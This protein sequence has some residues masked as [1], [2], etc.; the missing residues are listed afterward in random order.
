MELTAY[1]EEQI[2]RARASP[3]GYHEFLRYRSMNAGVYVLPAGGEDRQTPHDEDELY[4]VVR[5]R[6]RF[7]QGEEDAV[8]AP[9]Q[10]FFVRAGTPHRFHS[11]VEELV[12]LVVFASP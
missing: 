5:G 11:I 4:Y 9:Q 8:V 12:L 1:L 2:R 3:D 7:S 6:G 10:L